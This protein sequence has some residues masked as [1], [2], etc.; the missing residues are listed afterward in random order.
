[1]SSDSKIE[2]LKKLI[3]IIL[4]ARDS[5]FRGNDGCEELV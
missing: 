5:R 2:A 1:M 4:Q 3:L